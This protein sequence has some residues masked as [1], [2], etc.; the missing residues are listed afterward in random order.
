MLASTQPHF[1][2]LFNAG[3]VGIMKHNIVSQDV[4]V[5]VGLI[6]SKRRYI[7][8]VELHDCADR[9]WVGGRYHNHGGYWMVKCL[10][11]CNASKR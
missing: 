7:W 2:L 9:V 4:C 11:F 1:C 8:V 5:H 3:A 10:V 6:H